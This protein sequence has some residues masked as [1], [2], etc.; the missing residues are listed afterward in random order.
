MGG[1]I[2]GG[3][4][5]H[6]GLATLAGGGAVLLWA[7][8]ALLSRAASGIPPFQLVATT[9]AISAIAGLALLAVQGRLNELR[10]G[11][12]AWLHGVGGLFGF[13]ALYFASLRLAPPAEANLVNYT[14]PLLIVLFSAAV[15]GMRLTPRHLIGAGIGAA[16]C[17]LLLGRQAAFPAGAGL[18]YVL[19]AGSALT[20]ALYSVVSRRLAAVPSGALAGFCA[21]VAV[22]AGMVHLL[23]EPAVAPGATGWLAIVLLGL[24]PV[25][26][27]FLLWD[28]GMKR[29]DPRLLGTLAFA[30]PVLSTAFLAAAGYAAL[31]LRLLGSAALVALG[32]FIASRA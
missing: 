14:W 26:A 19:A 11:W 28:I 18:G 1:L 15:L 12:A 13:H 31:D 20:W 7:F 8:L 10:Q 30:T 24:G 25:G 29:G 32:G 5:P 3:A 22:L 9:F 17:L 4:P 2:P 23:V 6:A 27:A 16:G 21:G